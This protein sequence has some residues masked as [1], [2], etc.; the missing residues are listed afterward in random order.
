M[1]VTPNTIESGWVKEEYTQMIHQE[2][3]EQ[4]FS[5]IP[6]VLG[7]EIPDFPFLKDILWIDF[8]NPSQ[9][10][11][12]FHNLVCALKDRPPSH[13]IE[14]K[15]EFV[16]PLPPF[17][18]KID[19]SKDELSFI[20][21][22]FNL[23]SRK[24]AVIMLVQQDRWQEGLKKILLEEAKKRY[25]KENVLHF[26]PPFSSRI[27]MGN[28]FSLLGKQCKFCKDIQSSVSLVSAFEERL[29][30]KASMF[31]LVSGFENGCKE[32][33]EELAGV[34]RGL[35]ERFPGDIKILICGGEKL[36]ELTYNGELSYLNHAE[37][38]ECP[39]LTSLDIKRRV[40]SSYQY[41]NIN[42]LTAEKLLQISGG[43]PRILDNCI[44]LYSENNNFTTSD[45]KEV[46]FQS[47]FIWKLFT[48]FNRDAKI[49][50]KVC[51]LLSQNDV[52]PSHLFIYDP[53]LRKLYWRNLVKRGS[54]NRRLYWRCDALR[55]VGQQILRCDK[56][57]ET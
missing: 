7:E 9:Y 25:G 53:L 50:S 38:N 44:E 39:E 3:E 5:I 47:P 24:E 28:Y 54:S 36:E 10:R 40:E 41:L 18:E 27:D 26:V 11:K 56:I 6:V 15:G 17:K 13:R 20:G 37:I 57:Y 35:N 22:L 1:V 43:H 48:P 23:L 14:L 12:S 45:I 19:L 2:K 31:L 34:L 46:L 42:E 21:E 16:L 30:A 4:D 51:E 32:G 49:R 33:Q 52:G 8:R 29:D 55:Q